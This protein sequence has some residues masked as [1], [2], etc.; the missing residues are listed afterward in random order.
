MTV[1]RGLAR[2]EVEVEVEVDVARVEGTSLGKELLQ[3]IELLEGRPRGK[4]RDEPILDLIYRQC[5][6]LLD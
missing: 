5:L 3:Q 6:P 1:L 2:F 4:A